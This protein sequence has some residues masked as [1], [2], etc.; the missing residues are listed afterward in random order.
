[1]GVPEFQ[2]A[3]IFIHWIETDFHTYCEK[4]AD[5]DV[6][7]VLEQA[8]L[9]LLEDTHIWGLQRRMRQLQ[10]QWER[11]QQGEVRKQRPPVSAPLPRKPRAHPINMDYANMA[12]AERRRRGWRIAERPQRAMT[13]VQGPYFIIHLYAGRRRD[14]DFHAQMHALVEAGSVPWSAAIT[15]I[16]IDTAISDSMDGHSN[17]I[18]AFLL[19]AARSGRILALL[20]GPPCETWSSA[21]Y[22]ELCDAAGNLLRGP[23]PLRSAETCWGLPGLSLSAIASF[24]EA[25]GYA[26]PW[27]AQEAVFYLNIPHRHIRWKDQQFGEPVL[28]SYFSEKDGCSEGIP[29]PRDDMVPVDASLP[30]CCTHTVPSL[31]YWRSLRWT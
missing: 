4:I 17:R 27:P 10:S 13:P 1:L 7:E 22:A 15:V 16:S 3:R 20:L 23:R 30:R 25:F 18:W 29:L 19:S 14:D 8:H 11:L 9:S 28:S 26:Y 6:L 5:F 24:F 21:R 12:S 2:A 31:K